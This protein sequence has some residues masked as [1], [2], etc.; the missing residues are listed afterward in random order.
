M[1]RLREGHCVWV[2][3]FNRARQYVSFC[4]CKWIVFWSKNPAPLI[5]HL[6]ELRDRGLDVSVQ[7]TLNDY[8]AEGLEPGLPLLRRR[9]ETFVRLSELLGRER[10]L[11]RFDPLLLG[12]DLPVDE[13]LE[14][15]TRLAGGLQYFTDTLTFS[16]VDIAPYARVRARMRKRF[17]AIREP[18]REE[19]LRLAEGIA[20]GNSALRMPL[21]LAACAEN[22][23]L[24]ASGIR[25]ASCV[26]AARIG[27]LCPEAVSLPPV[28]DAGQRAA[29]RC[30]PSKDIGAYGTCMYNCAYCYAQSS[31]NASHARLP[32]C[33]DTSE[34]L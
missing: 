31:K 4:H 14:R 20:Q 33:A 3:P 5:P 11:W 19:V 12:A 2:N 15:I 29:C 23:D 34:S 1:R 16:F 13:L 10:V 32:F 22:A 25:A 8:E 26:D 7:F 6:E 30:A 21:A 9:V 28:R 27:R 17:P 18:G 24:S